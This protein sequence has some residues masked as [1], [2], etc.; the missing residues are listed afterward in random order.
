[1]ALLTKC[2]K[3]GSFEWT[4]VAQ[5]TFETITGKLCPTPIIDLPNFELLF[6]VESE[7]SNNGI[8]AVFT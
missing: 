1:M 6:E 8:G 4:K 3:N 5:R 7:A 2:M